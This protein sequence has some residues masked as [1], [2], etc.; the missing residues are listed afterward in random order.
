MQ[1]LVQRAL[2]TVVAITP[3]QDMDILGAF[4]DLGLI[5]HSFGLLRPLRPVDGLL[6]NPVPPLEPVHQTFRPLPRPHPS[7]AREPTYT[8]PSR[9]ASATYLLKPHNGAPN[10]RV[11]P[12]SASKVPNV[13][14]GSS[15]VDRPRRL[16]PDRR[17]GD[18]RA[19]PKRRPPHPADTRRSR[20][21]TGRDR[22][23]DTLTVTTSAT[24]ALVKVADAGP[25]IPAEELPY[26]FQRLWRG[27]RARAGG[28]SGIGLVVVN[29]LITAHAAQGR[30]TGITAC[31][32]PW[33]R[34]ASCLAGKYPP[35]Y[36]TPCS[37][38]SY[39]RRQETPGG[40]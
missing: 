34:A 10:A 13:A 40:I 31:S 7:S 9:A 8:V 35:G 5:V 37:E 14:V 33:H 39:R 26:V 2:V 38:E 22:P 19:G 17:R 12:P 21:R 16:H 29:E 30:D 1:R 27:A 28:G 11:T 23:G 36:L 4:A 18:H 3:G 15:H 6:L 32:R 25:G 20:P 24:P